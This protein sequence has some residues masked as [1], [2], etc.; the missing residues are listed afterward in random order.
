MLE[1]LGGQTVT[2]GNSKCEIGRVFIVVAIGDSCHSM[3]ALLIIKIAM[4]KL[5]L[6]IDTQVALAPTDFEE[7]I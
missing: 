3:Y 2:E 6:I 7:E 4:P 5:M 1:P